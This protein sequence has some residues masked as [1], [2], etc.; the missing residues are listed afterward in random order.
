MDL[1]WLAT[2]LNLTFTIPKCLKY[3]I[4]GK[5]HNSKKN[6]CYVWLLW[7]FH[8]IF[9]FKHFGMVNVKFKK[10]LLSSLPGSYQLLVPAIPLFSEYQSSFL[11]KKTADALVLNFKMRGAVPPVPRKPS[12]HR[13]WLTWG[14]FYLY[15][16]GATLKFEVGKQRCPIF[17]LLQLSC[18]G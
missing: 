14:K 18:Y 12:W 3:K 9:Y 17:V 4:K 1:A 2:N 13:E 11:K 16:Y 7:S 15:T 8:L 6:Y 5:D 10:W